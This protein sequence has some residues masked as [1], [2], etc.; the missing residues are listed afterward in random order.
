MTAAPVTWDLLLPTMP[1]RHD[2][3]WASSPR[4]TGSGSRASAS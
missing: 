3:M 1:H 4:L 2:Q